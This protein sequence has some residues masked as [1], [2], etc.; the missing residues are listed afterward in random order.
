MAVLRA[1]DGSLTDLALG[2]GF[3]DT[4]G[5]GKVRVCDSRG[6]HL[7]R[8]QR[9]RLVTT[10]RPAVVVTGKVFGGPELEVSTTYR[11]SPR[12]GHLEL[13]TRIV[14]RGASPRYN[15]G[16]CDH[17]GAGNTRLMVSGPGEVTRSTR[18][19]TTFCGRTEGGI[20][21]VLA[22]AEGR[23]M[24]LSLSP[25]PPAGAFA[26]DIDADHGRVDLGP[27]R[28]VRVRRAL[29]VSKGG[30][31]TALR[32]ALRGVASRR[33]CRKVRVRLSGPLV[34]GSRLVLRRGERV[35]LMTRLDAARAVLE[36]PRERGE[37]SASLWMPGVGE[38]PSI[39]L[40]EAASRVLELAP[41][42]QGRL[43][44]EV[45]VG[46][47]PTPAKLIVEGLGRTENPDWGGGGGPRVNNVVYTATGTEDLA[48]APGRYR[49]TAT[50]GPAYS[51]A[52]GVVQVR[53]GREVPLPLGLRGAVSA[54]G[55][56]AAEL[57]AHTA[58]SFDAPVRART[59]VASALALGVELM[60]V[61]DHNA[62]TDL[63]GAVKALG[64]R[65][66]L[67]AGQEVTTQGHLFGHFNVFPLDPGRAPLRWR[68]TSP[69]LLF[70]EARKRKKSLIQ[71]NHPQMG[72]IGYFDQMGLDA[73]TGGARSPGYRGSFDLLEV[74]NGD[75]LDHLD[76][77]RRNL[78]TWFDLLNSGRR[79]VAT[80]GS[81]AHR[82]PFQDVGYPRN[83]I[84]WGRGARSGRAGAVT[85]GRVLEALR[86]G[87]C[88]VTSGPLVQLEADG[89]PV[90][91]VVKLD[92]PRPVLLRLRVQAAPW[93]DVAEVT[94]VE[95]GRPV[96]SFQTGRARGVRRLDRTVTVRPQR[97]TWY[98]VTAAGRRPD[99]TQHRR[100]IPFA[101]TNPI[102]IDADGDG[103]CAPCPTGGCR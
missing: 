69:A 24:R 15:V 14:N 44:V 67:V 2:P 80:G 82:L 75:H 34:P 17:I 48:L 99:P 84:R 62:V 63:S 35:M 39:T 50:R 46:R 42:P 49:V 64:G 45:R 101:V 61:T 41:P 53:R 66:L 12:G 70:A 87:R 38:G 103:R 55:W 76:R 26:P 20:S 25:S 30:L 4:L 89:H 13:V 95:R 31:A 73:K 7:P 19:E 57:H 58:A 23:T 32:E 91:S 16:V 94:L 43:R 51:L 98:V 28:S 33:C 52:R 29:A 37:L 9:F 88:V 86:A 21:T 85:V 102:W 83:L 81:D 72:S 47:E 68:H 60:A 71:V 78:R 27:G 36:L 8:Q 90:G 5:W 18:V 54:P 11:V 74:F 6:A 97:D 96:Q 3:I 92:K 93:V 22:A 59:R 1:E 65:L 10:G 56:I 77:V 40:P 100:V 79:Y